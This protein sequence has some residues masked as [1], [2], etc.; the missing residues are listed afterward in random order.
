MELKMP[1]QTRPDI[2]IAR[3]DH[4]QL[5]ALALRALG[6]SPGANTLLEEVE[7]A[8]IV[9]IAELPANVVGMND[10]ATFEYDGSRYRSFQLVYPPAADFTNGRISVLTPVGAALIGLR[11]GQTIWWPDHNGGVHR[12]TLIEVQ[13]ARV[14]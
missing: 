6:R 10:T 12:L 14:H 2:I 8:E 7:R 13:P 3:E 1:T 5:T 11:E 9:P 4:E